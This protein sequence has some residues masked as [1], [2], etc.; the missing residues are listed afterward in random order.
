MECNVMSLDFL[1]FF[2][3]VIVYFAEAYELTPKS[4]SSTIKHSKLI[5]SKNI[6]LT[7]NC[8][9]LEMHEAFNTNSLVTWWFKRSCKGSCWN[10]PDE[11][12]WTEIDCDGQ[13]KIF[14]TLNDD[15]ASNGFYLCRLF[16]YRVD[17]E[18]ILQIEFTKTFHVEIF[19]PLSSLPPPEILNDTLNDATNHVSN[20][21]PLNKSQ[22][23][24]QCSVKSQ[25]KP[26]IKWFKK[27]NEEEVNSEENSFESY[28]SFIE[29]TRSIKYFENFYEPI[30]GLQGGLKELTDN[31]YLSKLIVNNITRNSIYVCV[32]IN[33]SGFTF[34]E[35]NV[36]QH[37]SEDEGIIVNESIM[38]FPEKNYEI[39]FLIPV[40]LLMPISVL[41]CTILYLLISRQ[42]L[43]RNKIIII[44]AV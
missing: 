1:T 21:T 11:N 28:K 5:K 17:E 39:L 31:L 12:E 27:K 2:V 32:A 22:L 43:K 14:L 42:I 15:K 34:R 8:S 19:D 7:L 4:D 23:I 25:Q 40:V 10:Q 26:T 33:Y 24:L 18:T 6:D 36:N 13:C 38:E 37:V 16:P 20:K 35:F 9:I 29:S 41:M 44:E 3:I 30:I